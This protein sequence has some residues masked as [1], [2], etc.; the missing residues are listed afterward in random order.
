MGARYQWYLLSDSPEGQKK[1]AEVTGKI[2]PVY[3][4]DG[5]VKKGFV[6]KRVP[7]VTLKSSNQ[8]RR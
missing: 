5:D 8:S 6:Y 4:A 7:H 1:E 3:K 2:P